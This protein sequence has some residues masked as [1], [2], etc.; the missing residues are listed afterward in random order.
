MVKRSCSVGEGRHV[1]A[2]RVRALVHLLEGCREGEV[3]E[4][5][6]S[7]KRDREG[8]GRGDGL[9]GWVAEEADAVI[10]FGY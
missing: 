9:S 8:R 6:R 7:M 5:I 2:E 10:G 1:C 3:R 4:K